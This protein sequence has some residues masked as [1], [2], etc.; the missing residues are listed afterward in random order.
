MADQP[1]IRRSKGDKVIILGE[2]LNAIDAP[3]RAQVILGRGWRDGTAEGEVLRVKRGEVTQVKLT[4]GE[5]VWVR[6]EFFT[7]EARPVAAEP[8]GVLEGVQSD[9]ELGSDEEV[10]DIELEEGEQEDSFSVTNPGR[11]EQGWVPTYPIRQDQR[12]LDGY[13]RNFTPHLRGVDEASRDSPWAYFWA[14]FPVAALDEALGIMLR[15][16]RSSRRSM[17]A[18]TWTSSH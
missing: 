1:P 17:P 10:E 18:G 15:A 8:E 3:N 2:G 4:T 12:I 11:T 5:I 16:G 7:S 14:F 6:P 13:T 9:F